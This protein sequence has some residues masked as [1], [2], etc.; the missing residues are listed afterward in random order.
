MQSLINHLC[1]IPVPGMCSIHIWDTFKLIYFDEV[2]GRENPPAQEHDWENSNGSN[3]EHA[4]QQMMVRYGCSPVPER[5]CCL[6][7]NEQTELT[8]HRTS[9]Q[10]AGMTQV[11]CM[12]KEQSLWPWVASPYYCA[13][14]GEGL[15]QDKSDQSQKATRSLR[16]SFSTQAWKQILYKVRDLSDGRNSSCA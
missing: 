3:S 6:Y 9:D 11:Q 7:S 16:C 5:N 14:P 13:T 15:C 4:Y 10:R 1:K 2:P 12:P 8:F